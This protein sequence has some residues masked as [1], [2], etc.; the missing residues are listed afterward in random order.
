MT[1]GVNYPKGLIA[2]GEEI[3]LATILDRLERA[4][5]G[6]DGAAPRDG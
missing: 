5:A 3:G 6:A 2:W 1:K 4:A